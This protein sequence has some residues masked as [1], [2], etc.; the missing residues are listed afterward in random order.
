MRK[1]KSSLGNL[2]IKRTPWG[3][4]IEKNGEALEIRGTDNSFLLKIL[5]NAIQERDYELI[6]NLLPRSFMSEET[7]YDANR[8][9]KDKRIVFLSD[10]P[11]FSS[12]FKATLDSSQI[13]RTEP[14]C[15]EYDDNAI[16]SRDV[17]L[18]V[19]FHRLPHG[20]FFLQLNRFCLDRRVQ[21]VKATIDHF[22]FAVT[23]FLL[24]YESACYSCYSFLKTNNQVFDRD[25]LESEDFVHVS[26]SHQPDFMIQ[27]CADF[28]VVTLVKFLT[29]ERFLQ[30]D[31]SE[32]VLDFTKIEIS[33]NPLLKVPFCDACSLRSKKQ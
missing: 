32:I 8:Q 16:F 25:T 29:K 11:D 2:E 5:V 3:F 12:K 10:S 28:L 4:L 7:Y 27:F 1:S 26:R 30:E 31:L 9:I 14:E 24:P 17:D 19:A 22:K 13:I 15:F 20:R 33:K 21:F 6:T 23:P 18:I